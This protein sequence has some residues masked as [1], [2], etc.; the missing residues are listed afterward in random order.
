ME[1]VHEEKEIN[2]FVSEKQMITTRRQDGRIEMLGYS[3][4]QLPRDQTV[5]STLNVN[6]V[7]KIP[8]ISVCR[9]SFT[10]D[11]ASEFPYYVYIEA[12]F[13]SFRTN[14]STYKK[15][16]IYHK[17]AEKNLPDKLQATDLR[18]LTVVDF[19]K[20]PFSVSSLIRGTLY[21]VP[22][23]TKTEECAGVSADG[24]F[25]YCIRLLTPAQLQSQFPETISAMPTPL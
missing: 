21:A 10:N 9:D 5:S 25:F 4:V 18:S 17:I 8:L 7:Y 12:P 20:L 24:I 14:K 1:D 13:L 15:V 11:I 23:I 16:V 2:G 3:P 22:S 6:G 19:Q